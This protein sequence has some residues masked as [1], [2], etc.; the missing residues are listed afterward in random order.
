MSSKSV[1]GEA[2]GLIWAKF[3][4][5]CEL[6]TE[7]EQNPDFPGNGHLLFVEKKVQYPRSLLS[8]KEQ[9]QGVND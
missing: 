7:T 9:T 8:S 6:V 4:S 5:I 3:L 2:W 1:M